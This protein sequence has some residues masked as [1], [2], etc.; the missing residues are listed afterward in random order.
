[1]KRL[2]AALGDFSILIAKVMWVSLKRPPRLGLIRDQLFSIG[3]AS[4]PVVAIT[5]FS[6]GMV[7]A[8]QSYFQLSDKGL[9]GA[10]GLMVAKAML[11][12]LG[13]VLTAF[14]V[15]GRVGAAMCAELGT[16]RVTEQIDALRSMAVNPLRHLIAPRFISGTLMLPLLTIFS[17]IMGIMGGYLIAVHY[18]GMSSIA[19]M[20]PISTNVT[21]FDFVSGLVKAFCFGFIIVTIS[22]YKGLHT[23]GGAAGVGKAT[24]NSVVICYSVILIS[25]FFLTLGLNSSYDTISEWLNG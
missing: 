6:T 7:L 12:E 10:T 3:V 4:L 18:Y 13:P 16:M 24:T 22:C 21:N 23:R 20:D 14:M 11:V 15:T 25:N 2:L 5:G 19:F 8:A 1:M 9:A 17:S